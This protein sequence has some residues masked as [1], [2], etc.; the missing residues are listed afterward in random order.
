M[1][2]L[3]AEDVHVKEFT[4]TKFREGYDSDEVD[5][6]LDE[7]VETIATLQEE[8]YNLKAQLAE[9]E[10]KIAEYAAQPPVQEAAPEPEP[11]PE[12]EPEPTPESEAAAPKATAEPEDATSMLAL[13]QRVHDEYV[14]NGQEEGDRIVSESRAQGEQIVREAEDE[15]RRIRE[16]L[17]QDRTG[18]EKKID[19]LKQFERD[20]RSKIH[21]HLETLI[22]EVDKGAQQA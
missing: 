22:N 19:D 16:K 5:E 3:T 6:F 15:A 8:N 17:E 10:R 11:Q 4:P 18:L 14:R 20:Y 12:P 2:L 9:A 1:A 7:V 21:S 13:A